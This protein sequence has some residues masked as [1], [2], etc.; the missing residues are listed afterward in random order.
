MDGHVF[1][2]NSEVASH[3]QLNFVV[4]DLNDPFYSFKST[5]F[6]SF[7]KYIDR[8]SEIRSTFHLCAV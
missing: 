2:M 4:Y 3:K 1:L 5:C 8:L 7:Q 6:F